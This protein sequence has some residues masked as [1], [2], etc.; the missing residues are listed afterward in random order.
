MS[1]A[2]WKKEFYGPMSKAVKSEK[3]ALEHSIKKWTGLLPAN[4]KK[5][6]LKTKDLWIEDNARRAFDIDSSTCA[7]CELYICSDCPLKKIRRSPCCGNKESPY[8]I[9]YDENNPRPMLNLLKK[10]LKKCG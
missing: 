10:A 6:E 8:S 2:T 4:L 5:H 7:L 1:I 9:W 3:A